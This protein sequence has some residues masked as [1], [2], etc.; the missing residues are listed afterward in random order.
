MRTDS[1]KR[2]T[3]GKIESTITTNTS[4]SN[5]DGALDFYSLI[6]SNNQLVFRMN[7]ADNENNSFRPLDLN[8]N[9]LKTSTGNLPI[10]ATASI[11]GGQVTIAPK[12]GSNLAI[13]TA[14][15][16]T[17]RTTINYDGTGIDLQNITTGFTGLVSLVNS[18]LSNSYL[19]IQQNFGSTLKYVFLKVDSTN[20]NTLESFDTL[21]TPANPFKIKADNGSFANS[22]SS[23]ELDM[24]PANNP[25]VLAQLTFTHDNTLFA[26][27]FAPD[28]YIPVLI[29]GV[30]YYIP[31][32]LNPI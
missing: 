19:F 8:G 10:D 7:G 4:P 27:S 22:N 6:N 14:P 25:L 17:N 24:N 11:G 2:R 23:I 3:F 13:G 18:V 29:G 1:G 5:Y 28:R 20:G 21:H 12:A 30:Q 16:G 26:S 15:T 32:T 31:I 9:T